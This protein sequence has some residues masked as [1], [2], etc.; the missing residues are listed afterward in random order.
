[1]RRDTTIIRLMRRMG[2]RLMS[3]QLIGQ[4]GHIGRMGRMGLMGLIGLMSLMSLPAQGQIK[5]GGNVYGGGNKALVEGNTR[6][7]VKAGDIGH[8]DRPDNERPLANP[9]GRVFGGARMADVGGNAF[10]HIDGENATDYIVVNYVYGG[11]D[12]AGTVG[13]KP[14][15]KTLPTE[16]T[17][18]KK[19]EEDN[20][21]P[22][23]NAIDSS[24]DSYVRISTKATDAEKIYIGQLFGGGNGDFDYEDKVDYPTAGRTTHYIYNRSDVGHSSPLAIVETANGEVGFK[25]PELAKAYLEV[26]GGSIVYAY[27]GG[28][29]ATVKE[30]TVIHVDNPSDVV[31]HILVDADGVE[32][33]A[34][35]YA[36][37]AA[38]EANG[39]KASDEE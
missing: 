19:T 12:V 30:E 17:E 26:V 14:A 20:T 32:A 35:T 27:G 18:I 6:V 7:T 33:N 21:N 37:Y 38:N 24:W 28:N 3:L 29:N 25:R 36:T 16:L 5:V 11:N 23:K 22:K 15:N 39:G 10:V 34:T 4:M 31:N 2:L 8:T 13:T 1:M 9:K